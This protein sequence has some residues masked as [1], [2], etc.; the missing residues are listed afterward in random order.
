MVAQEH[1]NVF[2][3]DIAE[4]W[5]HMLVADGGALSD[6]EVTVRPPQKRALKSVTHVAGRLVTQ[7]AGS[8]GDLRKGLFTRPAFSSLGWS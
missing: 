6:P 4:L 5:A 7:P 8:R 3:R 2:A 1:A